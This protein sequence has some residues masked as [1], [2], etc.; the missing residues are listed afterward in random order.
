MTRQDAN[1]FT[2]LFKGL[3]K[4]RENITSRIDEILTYY[5]EIDDDF[6]DEIE[7]VLIT[8]DVG[9]TVA[10]EVVKDLK[11]K[12]K[13]DKIGD[14]DKIRDLIRESLVSLLV[15]SGPDTYDYPLLI[16]VTGVNGVGKTTAIGKLA[17][18]FRSEGKKVLL[19]AGD[20]FRAAAAEQLTV[21]AERS[22][23][24]IVRQHEGADPAA[25]IFDAVHAG[26]AR[27]A[28][29]IICDTAGR[30]HNKKN[31]M[32]ELTKINRI[33]D[34]E[35]TGCRRN[36][37][38]LDATTGQNAIVQAKTFTEA[39]GIDGVILTKLDGT[40]KGGV[41]LA[42][43]KGLSIPVRYIGVGE[44]MEDLQE[45]EPSEFVKAVI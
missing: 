8:A 35:F 14:A 32:D 23:S 6:F 7:T 19:A 28:D 38:V 33:I 5:K 37:L 44:G 43:S 45:F 41:V 26:I 22:G 31:L 9:V 2:R 42:I 40:S 16:L 4:T 11:T 15:G 17:F 10:T 25:V 18:K 36:Y 12:V 39:V 24:D 30:L 13:S 27:G 1:L 21:W 20:T 29:V 34:R 3:G